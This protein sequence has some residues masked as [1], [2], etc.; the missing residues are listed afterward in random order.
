MLRRRRRRRPL[1]FP[2]KVGTEQEQVAIYYN[3]TAFNFDFRKTTIL[4]CGKQR[5]LM[6]K[7]VV[8]ENN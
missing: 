4:K 3:T 6:W 1:L 5:K 8:A 2:G 7:R